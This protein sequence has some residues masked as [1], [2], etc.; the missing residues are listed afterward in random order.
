[1]RV[2]LSPHVRSSALSSLYVLSVAIPFLSEFVPNIF[3]LAVT[4][5]SEL[6][7]DILI[8]LHTSLRTFCTA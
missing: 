1:M 4:P 5:L 7:A 2:L 8:Q 3:S 6:G